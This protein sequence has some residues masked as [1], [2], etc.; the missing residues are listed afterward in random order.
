MNKILFLDID[1]PMIPGRSYTMP[2]QTKPLVSKFDPVA[3]G[4][5][6][7][8]CSVK[9]YKIVLHTSWLRYNG[10]QETL[11]HCLAEGLLKKYFHED[12]LCD[13]NEVWRFNRVA[14]WLDKHPEVT[15]YIILDDEPYAQNRDA[16]VCEHPKDMADHM[17]LVDFEDG[18][19][20]STC[21]KMRGMDAK[22]KS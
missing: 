3:V 4:I 8:F 7:L 15:H 19:I 21:N 20:T 5:I 17:I 13:G 18:I 16:G 14:R 2:G 9:D 6:N 1:G 12:C 11:D 10:E 22:R